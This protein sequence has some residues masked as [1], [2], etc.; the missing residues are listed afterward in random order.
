MKVSTQDAIYNWLSIQVVV[1]QR[2]KDEAALETAELFY[3]I[4]EED[5]QI[6]QV[7][8]LVTN[9][10]YIVSYLQNGQTKSKEYPVDYVE[11]ILNQIECNPEYFQLQVLHGDR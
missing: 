1:N 9:E 10:K 11:V 3:E 8:Y 4:L 6:T 5:Y 7:N 2:P